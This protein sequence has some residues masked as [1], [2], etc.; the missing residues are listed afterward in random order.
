MN[1][2]TTLLLVVLV[3][4]VGAAAWFVNKAITPTAVAGPTLEFLD[5]LQPN[6]LTRISLSKGGDTRFVLERN[7]PEWSL[8]GKWPVRTLQVEKIV[9]V[10]T[11]LRS[12]F[13]PIAIGENV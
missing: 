2:K 6:S 11:N 9:G 13:A 12:R 7:G 8:P 10:L 1:L 5:K 3:A 4:G